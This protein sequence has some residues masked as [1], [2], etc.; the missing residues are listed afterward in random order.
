MNEHVQ[1]SSTVTFAGSKQDQFGMPDPYHH[2]FLS[3]TEG[4]PGTGFSTVTIMPITKAPAL[5]NAPNYTG[6]GSAE[7]VL[8]DAIN[9]LSE[10]SQNKGLRQSISGH[11]GVR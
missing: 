5:P 1:I 6:R 4:Q 10:L 9:A 11:F 8:A 3:A 2:Y 7:S